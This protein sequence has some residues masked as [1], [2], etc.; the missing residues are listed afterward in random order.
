MEINALWVVLIKLVKLL[1][2]VPS[3][4]N[5]LSQIMWYTS[6]SHIFIDAMKLETK[7]SLNYANLI[8]ECTTSN[9]SIITFKPNKDFTSINKDK[10]NLIE[11]IVV[12]SNAIFTQKVRYLN[13]T[14]LTKLIIKIHLVLMFHIISMIF[15]NLV[16]CN[17]LLGLWLK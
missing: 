8:K 9:I 11:G 10:L 12:A 6:P 16:N 14:F 2:I 4:E 15:A 7:T 17:S 3:T 5:Y 13:K 1:N